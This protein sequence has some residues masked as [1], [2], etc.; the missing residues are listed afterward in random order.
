M[1]LSYFDLY[2]RELKS[3]KHNIQTSNI[4]HEYLMGYT[5]DT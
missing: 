4:G 2:I 3:Q 5:R 1:S